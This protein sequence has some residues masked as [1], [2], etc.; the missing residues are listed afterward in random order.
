MLNSLSMNK[1]LLLLVLLLSSETST[2]SLHGNFLYF[3]FNLIFPSRNDELDAITNLKFEQVS[4]CFE[5]IQKKYATAFD[6]KN[7]KLQNVLFDLNSN[8]KDSIIMKERIEP[9]QQPQPELKSRT[10]LINNSVSSNTTSG[11]PIE[12]NFGKICFFITFSHSIP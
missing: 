9:V 5:A 6:M 1:E 12:V 11:K 2:K 8:N 10:N 4:R 3:K 7:V